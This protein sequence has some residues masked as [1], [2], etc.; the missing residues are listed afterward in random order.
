MQRS[1]RWSCNQC[2]AEGTINRNAANPYDVNSRVRAEHGR[3]SPQC[4][5]EPELEPK[6]TKRN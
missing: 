2:G 6:R 1:I 5:G 4:N 3:T